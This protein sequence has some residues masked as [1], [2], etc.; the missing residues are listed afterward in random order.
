MIS[1]LI[2]DKIM[3][4]TDSMGAELKKLVLKKNN[5]NYLWHGDSK[6][7]KRSAPVLFPIVG[8]LKGDNYIYNEK[9]YK[10]SQHGFARDNEFELVNQDENYLTYALEENEETFDK[11]PF[12][13]KLEI[14]YTIK[15]NSLAITYKVINQDPKD[16]YFSIGAHPA[17]YWPLAEDEKKEIII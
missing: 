4:E 8:R 1:K 2:N 11:Y 14:K 7:W 3:I 13:F 12:K 17:F 5:K 9:E 10:M 15:E 16:M 6:Y